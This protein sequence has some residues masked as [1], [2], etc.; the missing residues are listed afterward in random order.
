VTFFLSRTKDYI[1]K[2]MRLVT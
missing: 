1:H 2:I